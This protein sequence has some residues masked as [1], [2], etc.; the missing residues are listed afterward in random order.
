MHASAIVGDEG[1]HAVIV[2]ILTFVLVA[3]VG[4]LASSWYMIEKG[5]RL[6]TR[7]AGPWLTWTAAGRP[8]ADPYTRA[9]F[10]RRGMLPISS[11]YAQSWSAETDSDGQALYSSCEYLIEGEEPQ[12]AFWSLTVFDDKGELILNS[13]E[14]HAYNSATVMRAPGS[15]IEIVLARSASPGNWLPTGG[16]GR[17][18]LQLVL[19]EPRSQA[20]RGLAAVGNG[21]M[22]AI[23]R[24]ACR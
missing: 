17:L 4:G 8:E 18:V 21:A 12:A 6:T 15:R 14:R 24:L 2:N 5:S 19:E 13:A 16:A 9:H 3:V 22:P 7:V 20:G 23:R 10:M 1:E 11:A